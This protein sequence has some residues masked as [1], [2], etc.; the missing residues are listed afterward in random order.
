MEILEYG[1]LSLKDELLPLM[2]QAFWWPFDPVEFEDTIRKDERLHGPVGFCALEGGKLAGFVGVMDI[3]TRT[4]DGQEVVGGIWGVATNPQF[5]HQG[6]SKTLIGRAHEYFKAMGYPFS[7]LH[8]SHT[9]IAYELYRKLGYSEVE[10]YNQFS[11]CYK[12]TRDC[13]PM[14]SMG[15]LDQVR[16]GK[17]YDKKMDGAT[18]FVIRQRD[19]LEMLTSRKKI[20]VKKSIQA[21]NGY[22]LISEKG[23][24]VMVRE[25]IAQDKKGV[26]ELLAEVE[27]VAGKAIID[28]LV[29]DQ[30]VRRVYES[31]GY[32]VQDVGYNVLMVW[33]IERKFDRAYGDAFSISE[34]DSF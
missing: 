8:T 26:E 27:K 19:L 4:V 23:G 22:A 13:S 3:P 2:Y 20:D 18:G 24:V 16:I 32:F 25:I 31:H 11:S 14:K 30:M 6:V 10:N 33:E 9:L 28:E 17:I 7:F 12:L 29:T 15:E 1:D 21:D 5:A 34:L